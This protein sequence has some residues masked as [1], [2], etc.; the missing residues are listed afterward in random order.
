MEAEKALSEA[1]EDQSSSSSSSATNTATE[2]VVE[3]ETDL[4]N[5]VSDLKK[6][7]LHSYVKCA[8][9]CGSLF[10]ILLE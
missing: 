6:V 2:H 1:F 4:E 5:Q 8:L 3:S 7:Y 9:V 10:S